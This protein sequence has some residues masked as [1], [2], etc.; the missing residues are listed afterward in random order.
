MTTHLPLTPPLERLLREQL[1]TGR[2]RDAGD[3]VA[4]ALEL[5]DAR[6]RPVGAADHA[7]GLW[8]GR[9][10]DGLA[11]ERSLRDEWGA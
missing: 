5:L 8:A 6:P 1:A 10:D 3:V 7:F 9:C 4:A 11:Y 2:Y